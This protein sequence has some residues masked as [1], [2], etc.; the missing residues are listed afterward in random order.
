MRK[1]IY[2]HDPLTSSDMDLVFEVA[3]KAGRNPCPEWKI[4][5]CEAMADY[6]VHQNTPIDYI[7]TEKAEWLIAQ[8]TKRGGISSRPSS[9]C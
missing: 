4:L 5:F 7:P 2:A 8:F 3:Q 1:T 9:H 6:V